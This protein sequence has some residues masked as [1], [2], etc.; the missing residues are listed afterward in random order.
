MTGF[1]KVLV[2]DFSKQL[3]I[4]PAFAKFFHRTS[5]PHEVKL[6]NP[7]E[8]CWQVHVVKINN[9]LFFKKGWE[10]FVKD[11]L[12][13]VGDFVFFSYVRI[14]LFTIT[15]FQSDGC[16]K[17]VTGKKQSEAMAKNIHGN[18]SDK[19]R[20]VVIKIEDSDDDI[21]VE[22]LEN[23]TKMGE[24]RRRPEFKQS[25]RCTRLNGASMAA[26]S[27]LPKPRGSKLKGEEKSLVLERAKRAF[28]SNNPF[29][30]VAIQP[31]YT[32]AGHNVHMPVAFALKHLNKR[33]KN[34]ILEVPP[35]D[36]TW[37]VKYYV[38]GQGNARAK[39]GN[40]WLDFAF[41]NH[42]A[43]GDVCVFELIN[44]AQNILRVCII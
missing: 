5:L 20:P 34:V 24:K 31:S 6:Q 2:G 18:V 40:G 29:F 42:L 14:S 9:K 11:N 25:S 16:V 41:E 10:D 39:L 3:R 35:G 44:T 13:E 36:K 43:V 32:A 4:P 21:S 26:G 27:D 15:V 30:M 17:D 38:S 12:L 33:S 28:K 19:K 7:E 37:E 22:I 23:V 8:K 1:F